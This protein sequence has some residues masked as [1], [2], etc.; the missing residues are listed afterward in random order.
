MR[1]HI[2]VL[3]AMELAM[4]CS[5]CHGNDYCIEA[6]EATWLANDFIDFFLDESK[7][8]VT[9]SPT[10]DCSDARAQKYFVRISNEE[11][12]CPN[13]SGQGDKWSRCKNVEGL[14]L[15][16]L[17]SKGA[18]LT[19]DKME[20]EIVCVEPSEN[21]FEPANGAIPKS[22]ILSPD[23]SNSVRVQDILPGRCVTDAPTSSPSRSPSTSQPT[24][25]PTTAEPT[26]KSPTASPVTPAP[27]TTASV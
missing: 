20:L 16:C 21:V 1:T 17:E 15:E 12:K 5:V 3:L 14:R 27:T 26:T 9:I 7:C 25:L 6:D 2:V 23:G 8:I 18:H 10:A 22:N 24:N 11:Y 4:M 19:W 13:S